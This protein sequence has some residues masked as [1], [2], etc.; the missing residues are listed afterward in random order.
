[1]RKIHLYLL[2]SLF[3]LLTID[4]FAQKNKLNYTAEQWAEQ[5]AQAK[6][7]HIKLQYYTQAWYQ[8]RRNTKYLFALAEIKYSLGRYTEA[9]TNLD[10][11]LV[12]KPR[13]C[14]D[15]KLLDLRG[16]CYQRLGQT[17][18]AIRDWTKC[19]N[20]CPD[21]ANAFVL[22]S[23]AYLSK[24]LYDSSLNA[25]NKALKINPKSDQ[26]LVLIAKCHLG[27]KDAAQAITYAAQAIDINGVY[28]NEA[29][30]VRGEAYR[31]QG[32]YELA[33]ADLQQLPAH[34]DA[35][36]A[37][38]EIRFAQ[39]DYRKAK[40]AYQNALRIRPDFADAQR[41]KSEA[42]RLL[43]GG[44]EDKPNVV[45]AN[46]GPK[47]T[48]AILASV[49]APD[50]TKQL[51]GFRFAG[52]S[53][54]TSVDLSPDMPDIRNQGQQGSCV[55]FT[56]SYWAAY[57]EKR[58]TGKREVFSPAF[59][60][61]QGFMRGSGGMLIDKAL[62]FIKTNGVCLE[63]DFPYNHLDSLR[64]PSPQIKNRARKYHINSFRAIYDMTDLKSTLAAKNPIVGGF[65]IDEKFLELKN[66]N[67]WPGPGLRAAGGHAMLVVGYDDARQAIKVINS[68]G[69]EWSEQGYGWIAYDY[70]ERM[71][72]IN[73]N[74]GNAINLYDVK[75]APNVE[76]EEDENPNNDVVVVE[77]KESERKRRNK[78]FWDAFWEGFVEGLTGEETGCSECNDYYSQNSYVGMTGVNHNQYVQGANSMTM[79][80]SLNIA[81]YAGYTGQVVIY[82][83]YGDGAPAQGINPYFKAYTGQVAVATT[84]FSVPFTGMYNQSWNLY[85]PYAAFTKKYAGT[86]KMYGI[87]VLYIDNYGVAQ[88]KPFYFDLW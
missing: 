38:G 84:Q 32:Q 21:Y 18:R 16:R 6:Q 88:G 74:G 64:K 76:I 70:I 12:N 43:D 11:S 7:P 86:N 23:D 63:K 60:Y 29:R 57:A 4:L 41:R 10:S 14:D 68:W 67:V 83:Y 56:L 17:D 54:P 79:F 19:V 20:D 72:A 45:V 87:P 28:K 65:M 8:D 77:D 26:A 3:S 73:A 42:G 34:A 51:L 66:G 37:I 75:D 35:Q 33:L 1:M 48:G 15:S 31:Q 30:Y 5:A 40:D 25:A 50:K 24:V 36:Y 53:L 59:I 69:R 47:R 39:K 82:F 55:A 71:L 81:Q 78:E 2:F 61:N 27:K 49:P 13:R 9:I 44:K 62:D 22:L 52:A 85:I 80:G 46:N 58:E